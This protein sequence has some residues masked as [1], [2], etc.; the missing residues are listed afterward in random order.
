VK[1]PIG[2]DAPNGGANRFPVRNIGDMNPDVARDLLDSPRLISRTEQQMDFIAMAEGSPG[3]IR[4]YES[5][6]ARD[7]NPLAHY[8]KFL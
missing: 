6:S 1:S 7:E 4:T 5:A 3:Q 8:R 2:P